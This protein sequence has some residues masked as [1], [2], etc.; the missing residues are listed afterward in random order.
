MARSPVNQLYDDDSLRARGLGRANALPS[1]LG[2]PPESLH[3]RRILEI[4]CGHG[5]HCAALED[6][7][8]A[9]VV[10]IDPWRRIDEGPY[11]GRKF[12]HQID[13]T[14]DDVKTLGQFEFVVSYDTLEH[15]E[16]PRA[17]IANISSVLEPG[18]LAFIKFNLYRGASA[19]HISHLID[20]PWV[21][22]IHSHDEI[23]EML[24][25]ASAVEREPAWVNKLTYAHYI[26][27]FLEFDLRPKKVW[28]VWKKMTDSFYQKYID[29]LKPYPRSELD[30]DFMCVVLMKAKRQRQQPYRFR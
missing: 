23:C 30:R 10:G 13:A 22:L 1:R 14:T 21:H 15:V 20:F 2:I 29:K 24:R 8:D 28:Y 16:N 3:K 12:Y 18:G 7:F 9:E 25:D 11:R 5:E 4:G 6:V 19:S 27:L 17:A 26:L